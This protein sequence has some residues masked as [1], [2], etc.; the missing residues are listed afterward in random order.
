MWKS[1]NINKQNIKAETGKAILIAM[2]NN[3]TYKGF[4]FWHT[5]KLVHEGRHSNAVSISYTDEFKFH[6]F[7]Y[8]KGKFN[9]KEIIDIEDVGVEEFEEAFGVMNENISIGGIE[10]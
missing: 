5:K 8:G 9:V 3:S 7:K 2:P 6:L 4:V 10:R 1:I